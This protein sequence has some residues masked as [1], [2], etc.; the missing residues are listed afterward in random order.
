MLYFANEILSLGGEASMP[1]PKTFVLGSYIDD[2]DAGFVATGGF[3]KSCFV[4]LA[5]LENDM[6][7]FA[8]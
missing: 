3:P 7:E 2:K 6:M 4:E 8:L 1:E 5:L